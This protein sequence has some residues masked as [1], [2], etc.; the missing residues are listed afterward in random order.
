MI[1]MAT[2]SVKKSIIHIVYATSWSRG[3]E[4]TFGKLVHRQ[5]DLR[6]VTAA[7]VS[8]DLVQPDSFPQGYLK[9]TR[10]VCRAVGGGGWFEMACAYLVRPSWIVVD[11]VDELFVRCG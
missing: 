9:R 10:V 3:V 4:T 8:A 11:G 5:F 2:L 7:D 6:K 1:L